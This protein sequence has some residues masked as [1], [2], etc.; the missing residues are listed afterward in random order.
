MQQFQFAPTA[1]C[2]ALPAITKP[3]NPILATQPDPLPPQVSVVP[4]RTTGILAIRQFPLRVN[5]DTPCKLAVVVK[6]SPKSGKKKPAVALSFTPQSLP[7]GKTVTVRPRLSVSG[8][9]ALAK[10]LKGKRALVADVT[11][12]ATTP[13]SAPTV[14]TKRVNVTG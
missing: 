8:L 10:A 6:L 13:D 9:H 7:A 1:A 4:T 5:C 3:P 12:T 11:V 14:V 2:A